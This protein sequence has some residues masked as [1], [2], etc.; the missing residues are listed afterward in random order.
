MDRRPHDEPAGEG[1]GC[2]NGCTDAPAAGSNRQARRR[3]HSGRE[4]LAQQGE[5]VS[6]GRFIDPSEPRHQP[7]LV[8]RPN[9][10]EHDLSRSSTE[11]DADASRVRASLRGHGRDDDGPDVAIHLVGRDYDAWTRLS[12]LA[13]LG[14]I[15]PDE[16]DV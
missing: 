10:V 14:G 13:T 16:V 2:V 15:E 6:G 7:G 8:D 9:L 11:L 12:Y 4:Q 3:V 1:A 5:H